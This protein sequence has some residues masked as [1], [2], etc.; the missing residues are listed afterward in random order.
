VSR[1]QL[2][3]VARDFLVRGRRLVAV[4][5]VSLELGSGEVLG[6]V[7]ESGCGKSTLAR[8][9]LRLIDCDRGRVAIDGEDVT[10]RHG[11][12][13]SGFRRRVQI[14]FQDPLAALNPRTPI[15]RA[16]AQPLAVHRLAPRAARAAAA[17]ALLAEV[18]L[19]RQLLDRRPHEL[20]GGQRQRVCI[21]RAL[22][23]QPDFLICDEPVAALDVSV[24][25]QILNL[26][27][28]LRARSGIGILFISHDLSV[29]RHI[30]GRVA[31]MYLGRIV[32]EGDGE[33]V[34][35]SPAHPYTRALAAAAPTGEPGARRTAARPP[36]IAG[37]VPSPTAIPAG[38]RFRGRCP[39][40]IPDC[41]RIDPPL[42]PLGPDRAVAC[43]RA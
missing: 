6:L 27:G 25:A 30:A 5:G 39:I 37:E 1:L 9:A 33:T 13:L 12:A 3:D 21:A 31:V 38:C 34:W 43:I 42:R 28:A 10:R 18:G 14:V 36:P 32:E 2:H 22:A 35:R 8:L 17:E 41:A 20:S 26:L 4:D 15:G 40:A 29:V 24:R 16:V 11:R 23:C 7:G 19:S